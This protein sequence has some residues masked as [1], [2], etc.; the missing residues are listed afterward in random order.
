MLFV[1]LSH[2][3]APRRP[4]ATKLMRSENLA[5]K[6][7]ALRSSHPSNLRNITDDVAPS[8]PYGWRMGRRNVSLSLI[9]VL[10]AACVLLAGLAAS[11]TIGAG[12][13]GAVAAKK[14]HRKKYA[15]ISG[16]LSRR[17]YTLIA[18]VDKS[19]AAKT[20]RIKGRRFKLRPPA[21]RVTL[22]LRAP[23]GT[24]AGP[25]V[26]RGRSGKARKSAK[27]GRRAILG[28]KAG[29]HLG[30]IKIKRRAGYAL[31]KG[32]AGK[33]LFG[34][35]F[36]TARKGVPIGAGNLG[37]VR[38]RKLRGPKYDRDRDGIPT[39]L[40]VDDDGDLVLDDVR[41]RTKGKSSSASASSAG[42]LPQGVQ[43]L[44]FLSLGPNGAPE[45]V[46]PPPVVN[47]D[48]PGLSDAQIESGLR[49]A[50]LL[51]LGLGPEYDIAELNCG[52]L[53]YCSPGGTGIGTGF[54]DTIYSTGETLPPIELPNPVPFPACCDPDGDGFGTLPRRP[55]GGSGLML[56]P[57]AGADQIRGGDLLISEAKVTT[58]GRFIPN[59]LRDYAGQQVELVSTLKTIFVTTPAIASYTDELGVTHAVSYPS[60]ADS[61]NPLPVVDGP[62]PGSDVSVRLT[63]WRPQRRALPDELPPG[64]SKWVDIGGLDYVTGYAKGFCQPDSYSDVDP[65]LTLIPYTQPSPTGSQQVTV[66]R[67][68]APDTAA[69][70]ANT[71]SYTL[72]LSKCIAANSIPGSTLGPGESASFNF[73]ARFPLESGSYTH[74]ISSSYFFRNQP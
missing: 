68:S 5:S 67:D 2:K 52:G 71:F 30:K 19:S 18:L 26:L 60:Y 46:Q 69:N 33:W 48:A 59:D 15:P 36:A 62:D 44:I 34:K 42:E 61:S 47:A 13:Q 31:A 12:H 29:A 70:P 35:R 64:A 23:N 14:K 50:A 51:R 43:S 56:Q 58:D 1:E 28:V 57:H 27:R 25:I 54:S 32:V 16:K 6:A 17:G 37:L 4:P 3:H 24:Y 66:L 49:D 7:A 55:L 22:H 38:V 74:F 40:D 45:G 53:V 21:R 9:A 72:D 20:R 11:P 41:T 65:G 73:N 39:R 10:L 8:A 63:F